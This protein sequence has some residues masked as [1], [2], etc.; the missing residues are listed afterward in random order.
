[1]TNAEL[2]VIKAE[3]TDDPLNL[4]LTTNP[5]DDEANANLLNEVRESI[6]VYRASVPADNILIPVD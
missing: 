4:G 1:M 3:L 5:S 6:Q 2:E